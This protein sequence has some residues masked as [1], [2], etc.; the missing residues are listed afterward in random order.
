MWQLSATYS[1]FNF[2]VAIAPIWNVVRSHPSWKEADEGDMVDAEGKAR[3]G[4]D[5][6]RHSRGAG[7]WGG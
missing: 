7:G 5:R 2:I 4:V 6:G 1:S 3:G